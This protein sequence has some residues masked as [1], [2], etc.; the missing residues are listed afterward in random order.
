MDML[1]FNFMFAKIN[2]T[3]KIYETQKTIQQLFEEQVECNE[4]AIAAIY[5]SESITYKRLNEKANQLARLL[6]ENGIKPNIIVGLLVNRSIDMLVGMLGILK[7]GGCYLPVDP[8]FPVSRIEYMLQDSGALTLLTQHVVKHVNDYVGKTIYLDDDIYKGAS[9]NLVHVNSSCDL[10]YVIYT[11]GSSG[12]P[13]GVMLEHQNVHNFILGISD[14]IEFS[15]EKKLISL[16]TISFDIFVLESLLPLVIGMVIVIA[17]PMTFA[18]DLK[19]ERVQMLQTTPSTMRLIINDERNHKYLDSLTDIMLG[20]EVFPSQLLLQLKQ[21]TKARIYNMYGPTE[22]TVWSMV[23][24]LSD[25][26][27]ITIGLPIANTQIYLVDE[28]Y[29]ILPIGKVGE[30]CIA[31]DGVARGYLYR[32]ELTEER[33]IV[34][35]LFPG[36]RMYRTGDLGK[37]LDNGE[38]EF[39]GR[40]DSQVKIR[41]FRIELGEIETTLLKLPEVLDCVV[42]AKLND[43][44]ENYLVAYYV[45]E[46]SLVIS[47]IIAYLKT[48]LPMYMIPG[49]YIKIDKIPLTPNGKIN[50]LAL[51]E[52]KLKRPN[53]NTEYIEPKTEKEIQI[54]NIWKR[55]C[56]YNH[57][58]I[59]DD[60]FDLGGN[61]ILVSQLHIELENVFNIKIDIAELFMNTT[62]IKQCRLLETQKEEIQYK[63]LNPIQFQTRF[64][65]PG[66]SCLLVSEIQASVNPTIKSKLKNFSNL[67]NVDLKSVYLAIYM[68]LLSNQANKSEIEVLCKQT[69]KPNY[70]LIKQDVS[71]NSD[72]SELCKL[73]SEKLTNEAE[74]IP[75]DELKRFICDN[76]YSLIPTFIWEDEN[77]YYRII[78]N[79]FLLKLTEEDA[80]IRVSLTFNG[81]KIKETEISRL[82][83][84]YLKVIELVVLE[85]E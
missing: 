61:S 14:L 1:E 47:D 72:L 20:G 56:N 21:L 71:V 55:V 36:I 68:F 2:A 73:V 70:K 49:F 67:T 18:N 41:G 33:F 50:R 34:N 81:N 19:D 28:K 10:A 59:F 53:L 60:F 32:P 8:K 64:Y 37:F 31:G 24:N 23:K 39:L 38:V 16:T 35:K 29:E 48:I 65:T 51:P 54:A 52:P 40:I 3:D 76:E 80:S 84:N 45:S 42:S 57:I 77:E 44:G 63:K 12:K 5:R 4:N 6:R 58:G 79:E 69:D 82:L 46:Q 62:I 74:V 78:E 22:T 75:I 83:T 7:A 27:E 11:S 25:T 66:I 15:T 9:D 30:I 13:K 43:R 26:D 17:D 85:V